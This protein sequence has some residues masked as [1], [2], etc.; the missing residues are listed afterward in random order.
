LKFDF[1]RPDHAHVLDW[2]VQHVREMGERDFSLEKSRSTIP[3]PT[4]CSPRANTTAIFQFESRGMRDLVKRARPDRFEDIIALV[5]LYRP[6]DGAHTGIR[7]TQARQAR[8]IISNPRLETIPE[9]NYGIMVYQE[10]V[11]QI[12]QLMGGYSLGA[13]DLLRRAMGK[14][15]RRK[16]ATHRDVF[17]SPAPKKTACRAQG[18]PALRSDGEIRRLRFNKSH[19]AA[20]ALIAI[21]TRIS[22]RTPRPRSW[23]QTFRGDGRHRQECTSSTRTRSPTA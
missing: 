17:S 10:Q 8:S 3:R 9:T 16:M 7:G 22:R 11:M 19:A 18:H 12:A 2:A 13:A 4:R 20:Y 6:V 21:K 23:R 14:K 5:A 15:T 1:L